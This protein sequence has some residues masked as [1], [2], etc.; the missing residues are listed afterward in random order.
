MHALVLSLSCCLSR[1][2]SLALSL[3]LVLTLA[4]SAA[5]FLAFFFLSTLRSIKISCLA[6]SGGRET[7]EDRGTAH[8]QGGRQRA[9]RT[10]RTG[11]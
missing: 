7:R 3:S 9:R 4:A 5:T 10:S 2:V 6:C 11:G 8:K 1:A